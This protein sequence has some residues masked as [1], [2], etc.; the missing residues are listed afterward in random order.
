MV[1]GFIKLAAICG[2]IGKIPTN[3]FATDIRF[4]AQLKKVF[5]F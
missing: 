1:K 4:L 3:I 2:N 5:E